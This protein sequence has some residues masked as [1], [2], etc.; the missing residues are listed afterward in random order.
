MSVSDKD[1][2]SLAFLSEVHVGLPFWLIKP[3]HRR[4]FPM[5]TKETEVL[6][7]NSSGLVDRRPGDLK[8]W[9]GNPR[10]HS[11]KQL[12]KLKTSI[13]RFGFIA[14]VLVDEEGVVL[15]GNG[16]VKAAMA[17]ELPTIP[18]RVI[19]GLSDAKKRAYVIA[20]NKI[21][22]LAG[23]DATLLKDELEL[24]IAENFDIETT[25]F[26][27][28]EIDI[29]FDGAEEPSG[30]DPDD[31]QPD[32]IAAEVVSRV[33]DL[34]RLGSHA[35]L[36]GDALSPDSYKT[37]MQGAMAQMVISDPPYNVPI[38]G[39]VCGSGKIHHNEF[40]M[41]SGEMMA[42]EFTAFLNT[43]FSSTHAASQDGAVHYYFMDWRHSMEIQK[44]AQPL[45]G[46]PL[47]LCV[48]VKDNGGM[49]SFYRSQHEL[50]VVFKKGDT[51][52]INN[53]ELGQHGRY[54]TNVWTY[55]GVNTFKGKGYEL[56]TLHPTVKP[57]SLIADALRDC[58]HR[59]GIILDP[60][61]GSGTILI[62]AER[63]GRQ[64]RAIELDPQYVDVG[65]MRWQRVTGKQAVLEA[66]GQTWEQVRASRLSGAGVESAHGL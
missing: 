10:T 63:T 66:T 50:V 55:S 32:D 24:L 54:R 36:C 5:G 31:L 42:G 29:L 64:A 1:R 2:H 56:L 13:Q 38:N 22:Q 19:G 28:A 47:Q 51:A 62:A 46:S 35:L 6:G 48:W 30:S 61:A 41:A 15:A 26:S 37:I 43:A 9:P 14:P 57:A 12:A 8:P 17:L 4:S 11:D 7:T 33:G 40:K 39:H 21:A 53:F 3:T 59:Q 60:F 45:F 25:G 16:R 44:A 52:H 20:D 58:S 34:W 65:V 23:W 18:T 27:T 49:G